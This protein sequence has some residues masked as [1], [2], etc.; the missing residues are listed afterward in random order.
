MDSVKITKIPM[1]ASGRKSKKAAKRKKRRSIDPT[2]EEILSF[3]AM[4]YRAYLLTPYWKKIRRIINRKYKKC[5]NCDSGSSLD[6]HHKWYVPRG[7]EHKH[8]DC[9]TL[10]CSLCHMDEHE[11]D[12]SAYEPWGGVFSVKN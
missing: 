11:I 12:T 1:W 3:K 6:V 4:S 5:Q 2:P 10:L 9:L 8:L 7:T